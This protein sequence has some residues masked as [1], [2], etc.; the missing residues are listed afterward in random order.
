MA[1]KS[2]AKAKSDA[3]ECGDVSGVIEQALNKQYG[4]GTVINLADFNP[5]KRFDW[6]IPTGCLPLDI[7]IGPMRKLPDGRWQHGV[8]GGRLMEIKGPEGSGKTTLTLQLM[9][10]AQQMGHKCAF[11]D[12]EH[13]LDPQYAKALGVDLSAL[14]FSQ[15]SSAEQAL[16]ITTSLLKSRQYGVIVVDSVAALVPQSEL[17]GNVGD[18][19]IGVVARLMG[20]FCRKTAGEFG[21]GAHSLVV[22]TNQLRMKI[23]VMFGN[24]ETTPGGNALKYFCHLRMDVRPGQKFQDASGTHVLGQ[25][26]KTTLHKNKVSAPYRT[27]QSK[28]WYGKGTL[29]AP[30]LVDLALQRGILEGSGWYSFGGL[31]L[32]GAAQWVNAVQSSLDGNVNP[33][34]G[35]PWYPGLAYYLYDAI[36][37]HHMASMGYDPY[38]Q[39]LENCRS[40]EPVSPVVSA[41]KP[42]QS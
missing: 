23:G 40:N 42:V 33:E 15:P 35:E 6:Q 21:N 1:K 13:A 34:T 9:A 11:V 20:Q 30:D 29:L 12:V 2:R 39:P 32:Q 3:S 7:A 18:S 10:N 26:L 41:I 22:L 8:P 27:A 16:D 25:G 36:L 5:V 17:D 4:E 24:P 19:S 31:K 28:L 14:T 37:T 38:G